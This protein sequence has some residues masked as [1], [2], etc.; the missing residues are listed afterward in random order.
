MENVG[1][2]P[3]YLYLHRDERDIALFQNETT[4]KVG[5]SINVPKGKGYLIIIE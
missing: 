2:H 5:D 1:I 3:F 4:W